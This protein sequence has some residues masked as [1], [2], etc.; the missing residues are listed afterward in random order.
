MPQVVHT[1][2]QIVEIIKRR[3]AGL[4]ATATL[5]EVQPITD[6]LAKTADRVKALEQSVKQKRLSG[7]ELSDKVQ[8]VF[9]RHNFSALEELVT[10]VTQKNI[11]GQYVLD[12]QGDQRLRVNILQTLVEYEAPKLKSVEVSG[13]VEHDHEIHIIRFGEDG[14]IKREKPKKIVD[15]EVELLKED[16]A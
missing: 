16:V 15:V 13:K 10:M 6:S 2:E 4:G 5:A 9:K 1:P 14:S 12:A 3:K 11:A 8:E 7:V